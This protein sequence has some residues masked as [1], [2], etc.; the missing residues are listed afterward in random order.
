L[1]PKRWRLRSATIDV[2]ERQDPHD[3]GGRGGLV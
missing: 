3:Q 2:R 1:T